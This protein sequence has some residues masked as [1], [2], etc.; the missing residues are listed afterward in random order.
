VVRQRQAELAVDLGFVCWIS[1][2]DRLHCIADRLDEA[3]DLV[4]G[5]APASYALREPRLRCGALG[6]CLFHPGRDEDGVGACF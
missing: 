1:V 3:G 5:H 6:L 2:F 4:S